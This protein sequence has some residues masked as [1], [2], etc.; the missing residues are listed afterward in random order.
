MHEAV[1]LVVGAAGDALA[2]EAREERSRAG[3][4]E[5]FVVVKDA[6]PQGL[7]PSERRKIELP[8][9]SSINA[10]GRYV[11]ARG[12]FDKAE[13]LSARKNTPVWSERR[14]GLTNSAYTA[15]NT[16]FSL[17]FSLWQFRRTG[18]PPLEYLRNTTYYRLL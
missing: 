4:I 14:L 13:F 17:A 12:E 11:K 10:F 16:A 15:C 5:A 6:N 7:K 1:V 18:T 3:S 8:E 2:V 9:L